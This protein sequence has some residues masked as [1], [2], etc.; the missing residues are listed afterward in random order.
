MVTWTRKFLIGLALFTF[1]VTILALFALT[2]WEQGAA[3][4]GEQ[5]APDR[6]ALLALG[7]VPLVPGVLLMRAAFRDWEKRGRKRWG[8]YD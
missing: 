7:L 6:L 2:A 8:R 3:R 1:G 4:L 5:L